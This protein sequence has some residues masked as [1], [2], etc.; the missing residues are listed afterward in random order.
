MYGSNRGGARVPLAPSN[1]REIDRNRLIFENSGILDDTKS[2]LNFGRRE[3]TKPRQPQPNP[4][5]QMD[6]NF[7]D[8]DQE[9]PMKTEDFYNLGES[10]FE[11]VSHPSRL[12]IY[13]DNPANTTNHNNTTLQFAKPPNYEQSHIESQK[14]PYPPQGPQRGQSKLN[15]EQSEAR[16]HQHRT[17]YWN[18][19]P[20]PK[21][22]G[23]GLV[24]GGFML[25]PMEELEDHLSTSEKDHQMS[26]NHHNHQMDSSFKQ[27]S[28]R[29]HRTQNTQKTQRTLQ[30]GTFGAP[31]SL[32]HQTMDQTSAHQLSVAYGGN[33]RNQ[34]NQGNQMD[35]RGNNMLN[36]TQSYG[37]GEHS[38]QHGHGT[39]QLLQNPNIMKTE[40]SAAKSIHSH[41]SRQYH[42]NNGTNHTNKVPNYPDNNNVN[43]QNYNLEM[44]NY[45]QDLSH[46][47]NMNNWGEPSHQNEAQGGGY[48]QARQ[49]QLQLQQQMTENRFETLEM[50]EG[51]DGGGY[52]HFNQQNDP[53]NTTEEFSPEP[54]NHH[55][56]SSQRGPPTAPRR[57]QLQPSNDFSTRNGRANQFAILD[58]INALNSRMQKPKPGPSGRFKSIR[59]SS[60]RPNRS[61]QSSQNHLNPSTALSRAGNTSIGLPKR[62][63][64]KS[65][66]RNPEGPR[67]IGSI[68][69][70]NYKKLENSRSSYG[71]GRNA[72]SKKKK[73][74]TGA[75]RA[76][77]FS[78]LQPPISPKMGYSSHTKFKLGYHE[79]RKNMYK[80]SMEVESAQKP[81]WGKN[82][83]LEQ[84]RAN[85]KRKLAYLQ[86]LTTH[87]QSTIEATDAELVH[88]RAPVF[89]PELEKV[90]SE[91]RANAEDLKFMNIQY[92]LLVKE[93]R[94][95][96]EQLSKAYHKQHQQA[97]AENSDEMKSMRRDVRRNKELKRML[98]N[99]RE[100]FEAKLRERSSKIEGISKG[101]L[102]HEVRMLEMRY[103]NDEKAIK[104]DIMG[105]M[106]TLKERN[107]EL[108]GGV[109]GQMGRIGIVF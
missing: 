38:T 91:I 24:M 47:N 21:N 31:G 20:P 76:G 7:D 108:K 36:M 102:D 18:A 43:L 60:Y 54:A 28:V 80:K 22:L 81:L 15:V 68:R 85:I 42:T 51:V 86:N 109:Q 1:R 104:M 100:G 61:N 105:Y 11:A 49:R 39:D 3:Q 95:N 74:L 77:S 66:D 23:G 35:G 48:D 26:Q 92:D 83:Y 55:P 46:E 67:K 25:G 10:A 34:A 2:G 106:R 40:N 78:K 75:G 107:M 53:L 84:K 57:P 12:N 17:K 33:S 52:D 87:L 79:N 14:G 19:A 37:Y 9:K 94:Q 16:S 56:P 5:S 97:T 96:K 13:A 30:T 89:Q 45:G 4:Q 98:R 8:Y 6:Y 69:K 99:L 101:Q 71:F 70:S 64:S 58:K 41:S 50:S 82:Q 65:R 62:D 59:R 63:P 90:A 44:S 27:N 72:S 93:N 29:S 88:L 73:N 103:G 32:H